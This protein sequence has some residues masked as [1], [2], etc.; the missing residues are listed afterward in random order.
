MAKTRTPEGTTLSSVRQYRDELLLASNSAL[1]H[2]SLDAPAGAAP[3][4]PPPLVKNAPV[5]AAIF[6]HAAK[7]GLTLKD[8]VI[9]GR[10]PSYLI[11]GAQE[12]QL[13]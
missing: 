13:G 5:V 10:A 1:H 8:P 11:F 12:L 7:V 6:N 4:V 9:A 2:L 3:L